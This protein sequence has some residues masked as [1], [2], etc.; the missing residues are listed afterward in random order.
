MYKSKGKKRKN[1]T[2]SSKRANMRHEI[3]IQIGR[4]KYGAVFTVYMA[5]SLTWKLLIKARAGWAYGQV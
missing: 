5:V 2:K 4:E 3:R 1:C